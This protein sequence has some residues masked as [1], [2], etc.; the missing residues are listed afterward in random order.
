MLFCK[1]NKALI[2]FMRILAL[3]DERVFANL[4]TF[5]VGKLGYELIGI[6]DNAD[7]MMRLI[8][9]TKPDIILLD[10]NVKGDKDGIQIGEAIQKLPKPAPVIFLTSHDEKEVFE[11]ARQTN[12]YAYITKPFDELTLQR[13]IE[14]AFQK[15]SQNI[16]STE[17]YIGWQQDVFLEDSFFVKIGDKL[18]KIDVHELLY[19]EVD[20]KYITLH[21]KDKQLAA[22]MTLQEIKNK[23]PPKMFV[24]IH[25]NCIINLKH[26]NNI[27]LKT[28]EVELGG[29]ILTISK[30]QKE[31]FIEKLNMIV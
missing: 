21:T 31:H 6:A 12:P 20:L 26:I 23:I 15:H 16:G 11:R 10:I 24:Q 1:K 4:I 8:H 27:N 14:L 9:A 19:I 3:E 25:R 2:T 28:N 17:D 5:I 30:R 18:E 29:K 22:R 13:A 7:D